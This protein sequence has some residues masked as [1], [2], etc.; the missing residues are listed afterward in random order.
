MK[1]A[2]KA[3]LWSLRVV[4][5]SPLVLVTLS[6]LLAA[7][8]YGAYRWLYFPMESAVYLMVIGILWAVL[9]CSILIWFLAVVAGAAQEAAEE[10][11]SSLKITRLIR[12]NRTVW[13]RTAG[14]V[15]VASAL[16]AGVY[17][18][19]WWI[20]G[21]ALEVASFLTF[22]SEK[23]V[24]PETIDTIFAWIEN[25]LWVVAAGFLIAFLVTLVRQGWRAALRAAP[26]SLANACWRAHFLV[27]LICVFVF[28]GLAYLL[29]AW[30]P[31]APPG[32]LDFAQVILRN[33]MAV[34]L[35]VGG[36]VVWL[37]SVSR[38]SIPAPDRAQRPA[39]TEK[40]AM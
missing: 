38:P 35:A 13:L 25:I 4:V 5:R 18:F 22:H 24:A 3:W 34:V 23:P 27:G 12:I 9:E 1:N 19:F 11:A 8:L 36:G 32:F 29:V 39:E 40:S 17:Y 21:Y 28:G 10:G 15:V 20:E 37:L 6:A 16:V 14:F 33:S 31:L 2:L 30:H 7:E 26:R